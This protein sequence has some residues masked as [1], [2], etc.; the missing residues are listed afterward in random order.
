MH[1]IPLGN[2][3]KNNRE[4]L[5]YTQAYPDHN[6]HQLQKKV[7]HAALTPM[8]Q[9]NTSQRLLPGHSNCPTAGLARGPG[10]KCGAR[11]ETRRQVLRTPRRIA[12]A[13]QDKSSE[14]ERTQAW[15]ANEH[16]NGEPRSGETGSA[17]ASSGK[18]ELF[19]HAGTKA[20]ATNLESCRQSLVS[21]A[22]LIGVG[23][24]SLPCW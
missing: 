10:D 22:L 13:L 20:T 5:E 14:Y 15:R 24:R 8:S 21:V 18:L 4:V 16:R 7:C 6:T 23:V 11:A 1:C 3:A 17:P 12:P 9:C 2:R 19:D